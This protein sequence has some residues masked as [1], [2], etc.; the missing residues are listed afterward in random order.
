MLLAAGRADHYHRF[1]IRA[2][3]SVLVLR[4][5]PGDTL[6]RAAINID[7]IHLRTTGLIRGEGQVLA[8]REPAWFG[9]V[10]ATVGHLTNLTRAQIHHVQ[11]QATGFR[12]RESQFRAIRR[13]RRRAVVLREGGNLTHCAV[14]QG[15]HHQ[16]RTTAFEGYVSQ[17]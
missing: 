8:V 13:E 3:V 9:V 10:A 4:T 15:L 7:F 16:R 12:Q 5:F 11:V 17:F 1:T 2:H 14:R 6:R